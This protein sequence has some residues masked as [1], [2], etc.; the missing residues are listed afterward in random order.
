MAFNED[1]NFIPSLDFLNTCNGYIFTGIAK[2]SITPHEI[3]DTLFHT[4]E[5]DLQQ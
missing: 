2:T 3:F 5:S 1:K 4:S